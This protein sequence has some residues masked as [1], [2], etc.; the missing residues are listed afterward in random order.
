MN[1]SLKR[2]LV[3]GLMVLG[4]GVVAQQAQRRNSGPDHRVRDAG[5]SDVCGRHYLAG[6]RRV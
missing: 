2:I 6:S 3:T 1:T 4:L 5:K